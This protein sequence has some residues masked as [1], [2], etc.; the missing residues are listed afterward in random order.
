MGDTDFNLEDIEK[1]TGELNELENQL[2]LLFVETLIQINNLL[3]PEQRLTFL[4]KLSQNWFFIDKG[5][6]DSKSKR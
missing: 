5:R 4:Y 3:E 6:N 2:N 1:K